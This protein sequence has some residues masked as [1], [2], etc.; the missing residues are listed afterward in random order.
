MEQRG[1]ALSGASTALW[2]LLGINLFNYIDR[3]VLAAV[4]PDI[5]ATLFAANDVNAMA[6][7]G[8][9][10]TAFLITYMLTAPALGWLADRFSRWIIIG[11][12]VI[13]WSVA[14]GASGLAAT[15]FA[16]L[17]TRVFVGIGEGGYGP[18]APTVLADLFPL[19]TRGRVLAVFCAAIPV[20]SALGYVFGGL[21]NEHLG[22]RWAFYL[23]A[24]PGLLLG[25]LCFF[26]RDPRARGITRPERQR[27]NLD[28]YV[29]LFRT[30]SY[31]LNC[32]AQTA[33][34]FA[35]GGIGFW[36]AA[37][38]KFRGQPPSATKF[39]GVI[40]VVAGLVSTLLGGWLG[41][42]LRRRYAGSYFLISGLGMIV[43]FPL[44]VTMLFTPFPA[45]WFFMFAA[46]FFIFLNT[47]PSN[48]ALA[49]VAP[50][51]VRATAFALNILV[52]HA[53]GD[54]AAFPT[55]GFIAGHTN[56]NVAF[57][58]VSV[59]MLVAAIAWLMG[60][61]YLPADTAAVEAA[62]PKA[63]MSIR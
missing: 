39:F 19:S 21:I 50:P 59:I 25:L 9:L 45:A 30:P 57:L 52:I 22:W 32:A 56:M 37:Y 60:V 3:Q 44:F 14:S 61:K 49:N 35:I 27:A 24:P 36:V 12:A 58:F 62:T 26:Q 10:G 43:A 42:R 38:L 2:L 29:A 13:L 46:V 63:E 47:G 48:T 20:G 34:T 8:A 31:V 51:K 16:L 55:I 54:A 7:T 23:I 53:L 18:A 40:I 5:R 28:D 15:F 6:K 1:K 11:S 33:M 17:L 41:D 4:E